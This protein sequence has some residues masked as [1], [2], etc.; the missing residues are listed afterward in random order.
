MSE[1]K[2]SQKECVRSV[3]SG[4]VRDKKGSEGECMKWEE[5]ECQR[6]RMVIRRV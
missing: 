4:S 2:E 1:E 3:R 5:W 6:E